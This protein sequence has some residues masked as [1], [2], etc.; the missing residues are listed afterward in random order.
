MAGCSVLSA[1]DCGKISGYE[2]NG[3]YLEVNNYEKDSFDDSDVYKD[4]LKCLFDQVL[5][6]FLKEVA[7]KGCIRPVPA[8]LGD[9]QSL[10]LFELFW[11]VRER[12][13]FRKVS[14]NGLWSFVV[15]EL[16]L[17]LCVLA[18][19]KLI[20]SRY[21]GEIEQW[22]MGTGSKS[23]GNGGHDCG[24]NHGFLSL[25]LEREFRDLLMKWPYKIKDD[26]LSLVE[27]EI[28]GRHVRSSAVR[29]SCSD[30]DEKFLDDDEKLL[31]D[32]S[33]V[34]QNNFS[35]R[36]RKRESLSGMLNW[37]IKIAQHPDDPSVGVIPEPSKWKQYEEKT[38]WVQA[39]RARD[40]LL[41]RRHV[42]SNITQSP[43]Q[44]SQKIHPSMYED[45]ANHSHYSIERLRCSERLPTSV[46]SRLC[47]CCNSCPATEGKLTSP[48]KRELETGPKEKTP[49]KIIS[50]ATNT[51]VDSCGDEPFEK[52]VAIG[53]LFQASVPEWTG[54]VAESNPKWLGTCLWPLVDGEQNS[55]I[56]RDP[57]GRGRSDT[58]GCSLPG[59]VECVRFHIAESRM[60]L[61]LELGSVFFYWKFDRM[62][63]EVSVRWTVEEEKRFKDIIKINP[64]SLSKRLWG[65]ASKCFHRKTRE[66]LVSYYFNVFLVRRRSYQNRVTPRDI[67]SDD[68][69]SELGS[70]SG[71]FGHEA[72]KVPGSDIMICDENNQFT[73]L[74]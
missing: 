17:D 10:D 74:E 26:R 44:N 72:V 43:L 71:S 73:Y 16:G 32:D 39:I 24:G 33:I 27:Y 50:L 69:E 19:V 52:H 7:C 56:E 35:Y 59:S 14:E 34:G 46:K 12:G 62:G 58:C 2:S 1:S 45:I 31:N 64:H 11:V 57:I 21:L 4:K 6:A 60:K 25:E 8:R 61:K 49:L 13:G 38:L 36:K 3:C 48:R 65:N 70:V 37:L 63:E 54:M 15:M 41:R 67:D 47:S 40:A 42:D 29:K 20:Y 53:P 9:G 51:T 23:L 22:L 28:N 5:S 18:S 55:L 30:Y 68:D 66:D